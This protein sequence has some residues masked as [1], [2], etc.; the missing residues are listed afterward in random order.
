MAE[1]FMECP[2]KEM[3]EEAESFA[4][5]RHL[6]SQEPSPQVFVGLLLIFEEWKDRDSLELALTYTAQH[7]EHWPPKQRFAHFSWIWPDFPNGEPVAETFLLRAIHF[8]F[9]YRIKGLSSYC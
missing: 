7:L 3:F 8:D 4:E 2:L 9:F 1:A 5:L 6:L